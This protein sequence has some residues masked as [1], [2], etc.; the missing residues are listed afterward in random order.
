MKKKKKFFN[1]KNKN[2]LFLNMKSENST[3]QIINKDTAYF[4]GEIFG[5]YLTPILSLIA[6]IANA[7]FARILIINNKFMKKRKYRV[8][9]L[10]SLILTS[11]RK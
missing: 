6:F 3:K 10:K 5:Y 2:F 8:L 9:L 4:V 1:A 7:S 11:F